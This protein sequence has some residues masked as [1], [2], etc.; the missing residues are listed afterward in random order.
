MQATENKSDAEGIFQKLFER[1]PMPLCV[2]DSETL[3]FLLVNQAAINKYGYSSEEFLSMTVPDIRPPEEKNKFLDFYKK[4]QKENLLSA[5][6]GIWKHKKKSGEIIF[7]EVT[8]SEIVY[9]GKNA[10]AI[11]LAD[12]TEKEKGKEDLIESEE[13]FRLLAE[14]SLEG[15][16]LSENKII[17]DASEQ[18]VNMFGYENREE[19]IGKNLDYFVHP[20]D[21]EKVDKNIQE[22]NPEPYEVTCL[23]KD[24]TAIIVKS[25]GRILP[26]HGRTIR[27][28]VLN[29]ITQQ[30][31]NEKN[32]K[33]SEE[34]FRHLFENNLA[35]VFRSEV[36]GALVDLNQ[37]LADV[38]GYESI[39]GLKK[40]KAQD[41]YFSLKDRERYLNELKKKGYVKNYQMRMKRKDGSEIW[42]M[43]NVQIVND[44]KSGKE[45][46]EGTLIDITETKRIQQ[47]LQ[48]REENYKSLIEHTPDGILIHNEKGKVLFANPAALK[49]IGIKSLDEV[50]DTNLFGYVLPEYHDK[51]RERK[52]EMGK[53]KDAPFLEIEIRRP[54]GNII[55]TEIKT[56]RISYHGLPAVEVVLHDIAI[57]R[58]M[59][60]DQMRLQLE[61]ETNRELKREIASHIRTRQRLNANQ[62]YTRLLIDS[63]LDM[64]FA[65]DQDGMI[66]EFNPAAQKLFGYSLE[67][68]TGKHISILYAEKEQSERIRD[69]VLEEGNYTGEA[70]HI[71]KNEDTFPAYI[72]ASILKNDKGEIIGSMSN[73]RDITSIKEA[74]EQ[75]RKSVHEK[76]ILLKEIHHRV[77]NNMQVISSILKLQSTYVK[78]KKTVELFDE[79]RNRISSMA[80]IHATL[81]MKKDFAN[82]NFSEYVSN[83]A[84][85]LQQSYVSADKK[86][87]LRMDVP[88]FNLHIDDAIPCGL[89]IN[90][91]LSNSF[92][93]AF[94]NRKKGTVGI[95]VKVKKENII[96][97][98]WDDGAGFPEEVDYKNT[99]SLGLQ[100]VNSLVE[101]IE[102]KMKVESEKEK[103]TKFIIE[104]NK[105]K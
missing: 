80:F 61:E 100:L 59:Q 32:L 87:L 16:V 48:E 66:T 55:E 74:E 3:R 38:F 29:D 27:I 76:E 93:Y 65:C 42:I 30:K 105:S 95:S 1:N 17:L 25:K 75:L 104:F 78:D 97:A 57:Q 52:E 39:E 60:R 18:F 68:I 82:I 15:I 71:K 24:G 53:E 28:S 14:S 8:S 83:L 23:K 69:L 9:E 84:S 54:D 67:E 35:A 50:A 51:I 96:L 62:K 37:A 10:V 79:C 91:I 49:M 81:Y 92:K 64:I 40:A 70:I 46:I 86:I 88:D 34:R 56:S 13:R 19:L 6:H 58:Q 102:G 94:V 43:E 47:A 12:V 36:G 45:F 63:S 98:I 11:A 73:S 7:M 20:N 77:K 44:F 4:I 89:I 99:E 33:Q 31:E 103:G 21:K 22:I 5:N 85:N 101:Q 26:Y 2:F 41:L 72:S 90:E